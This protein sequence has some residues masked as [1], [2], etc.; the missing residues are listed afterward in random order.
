MIT[1][2]QLRRLRP[3]HQPLSQHIPLIPA[4]INLRKVN[5]VFENIERIPRDK[6]VI[7]A[8]NHTDRYNYIPFMAHLWYDYRT[9]APWVKGKYYQNA[10]I[11]KFLD[12]TGCIPVPSRGYII[13]KDFQ[14][15]TRCRPEKTD[16]R[17]LRDWVDGKITTES[18]FA[19][20]DDTLTR[21]VSTPHGDFNP[22]RQPYPAFIQTRY[23]RF[24]RLVTA[25]S[26]TAL[27]KERV[28]LLIFPEGTRS[29][30]LTPGHPGIAQMALKTG[31]PVIPVGC[32]GSDKLYPGLSP[33]AKRGTVVYR[34]GEP[35]TMD[36]DLAP[37]AIHE[38]FE[39]F[40][41]A[42]EAKFGETFQAATDLIMARINNLLDPEYQFAGDTHGVSGDGAARFV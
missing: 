7:F 32:N 19:A 6:P 4:K 5:I 24:M 3:R 23:R 41:P 33:F 2:R 20:A 1:E 34:I 31:V 22:D 37:F 27:E 12:V 13:T 39:P 10:L 16:Y 28:S 35:M 38:P 25:V 42:A 17:L 30:R 14:Q 15:V 29:V 9:I 36:G 21:Y 8:M 40:T 11:G 26:L 18:F